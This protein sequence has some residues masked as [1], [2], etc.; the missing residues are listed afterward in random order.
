MDRVLRCCKRVICRNSSSVNFEPSGMEIAD[1]I[2][3]N[4]VISTTFGLQ[5]LA[6]FSVVGTVEFGEQDQS[7]GT[8][9]ADQSAGFR[10]CGNALT[11]E[12]QPRPPRP[13]PR[14]C[15]AREF[16]VGRSLSCHV[17][18]PANRLLARC[19]RRDWS[20]SQSATNP[21]GYVQRFNS[22]QRSSNCTRTALPFSLP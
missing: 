20:F 16:S 8:V 1:T 6:D 2:P 19:R 4:W 14:P 15:P 7:L 12:R 21:G 11:G 22:C 13:T 5:E 18:W 10:V 3:F 9:D 17:P